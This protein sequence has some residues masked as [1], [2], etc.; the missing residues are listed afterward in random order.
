MDAPASPVGDVLSDYLE[1]SRARGAAFSHSTARGRWGVRFEPVAGVAVHV[2]VDGETWLWSDDPAAALRLAPGDVALVRG[3]VVHQLASAAG[4]SCRPLAEVTAAGPE[5]GSARRYAFGSG[6]GEEA[7]FCCGAY[8]FEG[9]LCDGLI[10][11]LPPLARVRPAAGSPLRATADL[12]AHEMEHEQPGQQTLLDR[13]LDVALIHLLREQFGDEQAHPP[14]WFRASSDAQVGA[15]LQAL[16]GDPAHAWTVAELAAQASLSRAAFAR[17]FTAL[18]GVAP[19]TYLA[20]WRMA[21]ARERLRGGDEPLAAV[22]AAVGYAS[23]F[24]FAAAFKR[25]HGVAPGRWRVQRAAAGDEDADVNAG[26]APPH[27]TPM[28]G[29]PFS[30]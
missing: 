12:L 2:I 11:A 21:L 29:P 10:A 20:D 19:L 16:H 15:A 18:L 4:A 3:D 22:A 5:P 9:D 24:S 17:R 23:E 14:A 30:V 25:R 8:R 7:V 26:L 6:D 1:R 13:L 28:T 27:A